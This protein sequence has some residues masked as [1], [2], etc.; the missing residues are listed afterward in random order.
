MAEPTDLRS[1]SRPLIELSRF[2]AAAFDLDGVITRTAT[3]HATVWKQLFDEF[4]ERRASGAD[5]GFTPFD[6]RR[7]YILHVD[8]KPRLAGVRDFLASRAIE[9][10]EGDPED[11]SG[12]GTMHGLSKRKDELFV[13]AIARDGVEVF[14]SSIRLVKALQAA[15]LKLAVVSASENTVTILQAAGLAAM[16][17]ARVDGLVAKQ[18]GLKGKPAPDTY[19][20]AADL[21]GVEPRRMMG[22][23]D[24]L[25]GV[26]ALRAAGYGL[27]VGVDRGGNGDRLARCGADLVA[28]DLGQI[29]LRPRE[30]P[31]RQPSILETLPATR[32]TDPEWIIE[33]NPFTPAREHEM[34]SL[35]SVGN[36]FVGTRGSLSEGDGFSSPATF[37]AGVFEAASDT[38]PGL[39]TAPDWTH[40]ALTV[41]GQ[42]VRLDVG[43]RLE[44]R[45]IL[46]LRQAILWRHWRQEDP[47]GRVT[48]IVGLR[49][50]SAADRHLLIQSARFQPENYSGDVTLDT[51][52]RGP[53]IRRTS[54]GTTIAVASTTRLGRGNEVSATA[55]HEDPPAMTVATGEVYAID[56]IVAVHTSR[57]PGDPEALAREH[58]EQAVRRNIADHVEDHRR[59]WIERWARSD[60]RVKGDPAAQRAA[61]FAIYHL[62][63]A[64]NPEDERTSI[65]ARALTGAAYRGHVFWDTEIFMLP[66]FIL[67]WPAAARSLLM[68]RSHTLPAARARAAAGGWRGAFYAWE[69]TDTGEDA[70]PPLVVQPGGEVQRVL[71]GEQEQHI[72]ADIAYAVWSYWNATLDESFLLDAGAEIIL[73]TARFWASRVERGDDGLHHIRGVI[74]PD[75]YHETVDDNAYTNA[76]ARWN[77]TTG[78]QVAALIADRWPDRWRALSSAIGLAA[79]EPAT[80]TAIAASLYTGFNA[81]TGLI[82]Q[83][84]GYFDLEDIDLAAFEPRSAP[85]DVVLGRER[86]QR[87]QLIKQADVVLL[88][89]LFPDAWPPEVQAANF[90]YYEPR[91]AHGSSLSPAIHALVAAR[92]GDMA[93][94]SRYFQQA[95]TIDLADN[96]GNAAGG[97]HAAAL[98]GL[99]QAIVFGFGGLHLTEDGPR[100]R[101]NLPPGWSALSMEITWRGQRHAIHIPAARAPETAHD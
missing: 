75:E 82:E 97:V 16:F 50:A 59:A 4:L 83:F 54:T 12:C 11:P 25:P 76:M 86:V 58:V 73:E 3:V 30:A 101:P 21:L 40:M 39:V 96:M 15:G 99:W 19:L 32:T 74:G 26:E 79:D 98:G 95:A 66:F 77:L 62:I 60:I 91:C 23:E 29:E 38:T 61:R 68:Y 78:Q 2:D 35:L 48:H 44:H 81:A 45:R 36:G 65:G 5:V 94:A 31:G 9:L 49:L 85:V 90:R 84:R 20:H 52:I 46:D 70:T 57:S 89:H 64:A 72:S 100:T 7:D 56:R 47:A 69:S 92:L 63:S 8:G 27:V 18:L 87:S 93:L 14:D 80:W 67:T 17:D 33:E 1:D 6:S 22:F 37:V 55:G 24:A 13:Q 43:R 41:Q 34:E 88:L 28:T 42:P 51:T 10:P 71:T 53:L